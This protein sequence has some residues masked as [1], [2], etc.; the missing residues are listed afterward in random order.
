MRTLDARHHLIIIITKHPNTHERQQVL[1]VAPT[2]PDVV[3]EDAKKAAEASAN[4]PRVLARKAAKE[5]AWRGVKWR[6]MRCACM[7][8]L[9]GWC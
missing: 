7:G 3:A 4:D 9:V 8:G 1:A 2:R 6:C 5:G